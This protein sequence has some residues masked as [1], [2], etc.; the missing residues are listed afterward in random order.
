[1]RP[2][3][4]VVEHQ[5]RLPGVFSA[6]LEGTL[7]ECVKQRGMASLA[8]P[9]GSVAEALWPSVA[10][11]GVDWS[12]VHIFW[13]D[14]RAVPPDSAE[15]NYALAKR[16]LLDPAAIPAANV[17]RMQAEKEPIRPAVQEYSSLLLR[18]L[19]D[20]PEIDVLI[21]GLGPDGHVCSLFPGHAALAD[22]GWVTLVSDAPKPPARR[23]TLTLRTLACARHVAL[24]ALGTSKAAIV[25]QVLEE[26]AGSLP[27]TRV[28]ASARHSMVFLDLEATSSLISPIPD[29]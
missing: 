14:E 16:L 3:R 9:G 26:E 17:H 5:S 1:M 29:E 13:G 8:L 20:P 24:V 15:S 10:R 28:L 6:W 4:L 23:I 22:P 19:G 12:R 11:I 21:L 2:S 18:E 7:L 27:A 25:R